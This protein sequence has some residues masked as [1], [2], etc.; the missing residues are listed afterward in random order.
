[1]GDQGR[2]M[3]NKQEQQFKKASFSPNVHKLSEW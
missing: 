2:K 1:M 3:K